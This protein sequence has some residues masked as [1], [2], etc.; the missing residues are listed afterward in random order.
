MNAKTKT[1]CIVG[2]I[3]LISAIV[4]AIG[5]MGVGIFNITNNREQ[6]QAQEKQDVPSE[7]KSTKDSTT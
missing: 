7:S 1:V 3:V 4:V 2:I 5:T 6:N